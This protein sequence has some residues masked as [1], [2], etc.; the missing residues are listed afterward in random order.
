MSLFTTIHL[1]VSL[2]MWAKSSE[3]AVVL[4]THYNMTSITLHVW[5]MRLL[6]EHLIPH[7]RAIC[8]TLR[9]PL[10]RGKPRHGRMKPCGK[11]LKEAN[12]AVQMR[13]YSNG[14]L[15]GSMLIPMRP[16]LADP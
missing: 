8:S 1:L 4:S 10:Q 11:N 15:K 2:G 6:Q 12:T 16:A 9:V 3:Q 7:R 13:Q 14:T 5:S